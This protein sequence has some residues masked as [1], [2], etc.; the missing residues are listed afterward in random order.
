V[1]YE[2]AEARD[3][4]T[5]HDRDFMVNPNYPAELQPR[6]R[7]NVASRSQVIDMAA[8]LEPERLGPSP[9]ANAGAPLVGPDNVVESGNG[10]AMAIRSAY[11]AGSDRSGAYRAF[12]ERSGFDTSQTNEPVLI[13]RRTTNMRPDERAAFAQSA[14]ASTALRMSTME[15][16]L[17]DARHIGPDITPLLQP[18]DMGSA[19]NRDFA[20]AFVAKLPIGERG[21]MLTQGGQLSAAG[22]QRL[23]AA[24]VARAYGDAA[25]VAR[26]FEHPD[27]NIKTIAGSLSDAAPEWIRL[28]Q[29]I[30]HGEIPSTHDITPDLMNAVKAIMQARDMGRPVHEL[31]NQGDFFHSDASGLAARMFFKDAGMTKF[32][33]RADMAGNISSFARDIRTSAEAGPGLFGQEPITPKEALAARVPRAT[34]EEAEKM[35][36]EPSFHDAMIADLQRDIDRG[37]AHIGVTDEGKPILADAEFHA[38]E[39]KEMLA[40]E[41]GNCLTGGAGAAE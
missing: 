40:K 22:V 15:Q 38:A 34:P 11:D 32:L 29:G 14:N 23:R 13:A 26:A 7:A 28:K 35:L 33:S 17:S 9:E 27:S 25:L 37:D 20:K 2:L 30:A 41:I 8:N 21:G 4:I 36:A 5:S 10:R 31:L 3:L 18:G 6:A 16:A 19:A 12:L 24:S 1:K 39:Q